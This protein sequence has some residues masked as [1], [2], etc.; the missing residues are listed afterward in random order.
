LG[1][2]ARCRPTKSYGANA[3]P[4]RIQAV[5][6]ATLTVS[7]LRVQPF[8]PPARAA[9]LLPVRLGAMPT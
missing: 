9:T 7:M 4:L 1:W 3:E 6:I 2:Q 5:M 8:V